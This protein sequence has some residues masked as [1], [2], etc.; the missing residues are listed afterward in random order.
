VDV[1]EAVAVAVVE[2]EEEA[3][4]IVSITKREVKYQ[5]DE[6]II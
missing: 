6:E 4:V 5:E 3:N 1:D 2:E